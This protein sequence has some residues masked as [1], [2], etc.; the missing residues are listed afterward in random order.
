MAVKTM[1]EDIL[2][3]TNQQCQRIEGNT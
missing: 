3:A 2:P 1:R